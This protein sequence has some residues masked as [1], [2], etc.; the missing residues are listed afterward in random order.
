MP[1][2]VES[3]SD[4]DGLREI[5]IDLPEH[6]LFTACAASGAKRRAA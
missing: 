1:E 2:D 6:D 3:D 5:G 4:Q